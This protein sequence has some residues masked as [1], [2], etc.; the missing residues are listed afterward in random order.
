[1]RKTIRING[2]RVSKNFSRKSDSDRWYA[3]MKRQKELNAGGLE[4]PASCPALNEFAIDWLKNRRDNGQPL[5]SFIQDECRLRVYILPDFGNR[6][7]NEIFTT[8]WENFLNRVISKHQLSPATRNRI[9]SLISKM[10][11]DALRKN[12]VVKNPIILIPKLK[13]SIEKWDCWTSKDE[14]TKYLSAARSENPVLLLYGSLALNTGARIGEI[15]G[16][17]ISDIHLDERR[18]RISKILEDAS[19]EVQNRTKTMNDRWLGINDALAEVF[20]IYFSKTNKVN[21]NTPLIHKPD[22]TRYDHRSIRKA[23]EQICKIAQVKTIRIHDLRHTFAS[24]YIMNGGSLTELQALLG[25]SSP[26]MTLKYAHLAP[27]FL[28]TRSRVVSFGT[29]REI[30]RIVCNER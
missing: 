27:G 16:L 8:D 5:S 19:G 30:L 3:E 15:L 25:H 28:E 17:D 7:L 21:L 10:Y 13:E 1:M 11:N 2:V 20:E 9:R 14:V 18:F 23:H 29:D 6:K 24:H 22:G 12:F 4:L 26:M